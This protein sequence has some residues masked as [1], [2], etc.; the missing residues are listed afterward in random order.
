MRTILVSATR[1][2]P[3]SVERLFLFSEMRPFFSLD[4]PFPNRIRFPK[5]SPKSAIPCL[6]YLSP[7]PN[8]FPKR[9]YYLKPQAISVTPKL[10][11]WDCIYGYT[12][13][14]SSEKEAFYVCR[15]LDDI[16]GH[17]PTPDFLPSTFY[18]ALAPATLEEIKELENRDLPPID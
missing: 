5:H 11:M 13:S 8:D 7:T 16:L 9:I 15:L 3:P 17:S 12:L 14:L 10:N 4:I 2:L 18:V 1:S 6:L